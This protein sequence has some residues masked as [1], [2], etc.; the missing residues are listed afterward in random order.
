[1]RR[2][3][4]V[5]MTA[6]ILLVGCRTEPPAFTEAE[7]AETV[8][9]IRS[10]RD[11]YFVA[12]TELDAD[13]MVAFWDQDFIHISNATVAPLTLEV[14]RESWRPLSHIEMDVTSD[15][16][17]ALSKNAGYTVMTA[18]YVV[19]DTAG[20]AVGASDWAGT[21]IWIRK[22]GNWKVQA[23]HEGRPAR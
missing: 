12:A 22:D 7:R 17:V 20:V 23:V 1:M 5:G 15:R 2:L 4:L 13:A 9:A 6:T 18:S 14:L 10:A 8:T 16:V 3:I 19:F 21:H 11:A